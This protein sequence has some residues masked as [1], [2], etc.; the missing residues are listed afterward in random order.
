MLSFKSS[1]DVMSL[2]EFRN[3]LSACVEQSRTTGRPLLLTQNGR[4]AGVFLSAAAWDV[5]QEK[6]YNAEMYEDL[7]V[8]EGES[9]RGEVYTSEEVKKL[10]DDDLRKL[11]KRPGKR[12]TQKLEVA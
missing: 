1:E 11:A 9:E 8:S 6:L 3:N 4:T 5:L 10:I 2:S 12:K 7:L